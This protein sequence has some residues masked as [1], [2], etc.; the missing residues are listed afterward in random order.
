MSGPD[1]IK[2]RKERLPGRGTKHGW[3]GI[4]SYLEGHLDSTTGNNSYF[5]YNHQLSP[6][7]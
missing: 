1:R 5:F 2:E 4:D 3:F 7:C 6:E